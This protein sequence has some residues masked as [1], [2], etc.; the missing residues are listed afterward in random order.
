M[1]TT[2]RDWVSSCPRQPSFVMRAWNSW[3]VQFWPGWN[4]TCIVMI[5]CP[6]T[7]KVCGLITI[8]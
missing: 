3:E 4:Y 8:G 5:D 7:N 2:L 1:F 6:G